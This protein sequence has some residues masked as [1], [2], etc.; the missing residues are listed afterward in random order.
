MKI[1]FFMKIAMA[2]I[3]ITFAISVF[4]QPANVYLIGGPVNK[5]NPNWLLNHKVELTKDSNNPA[6][7]DYKG[8][9]AYNWRGDESGNIKFSIG[10]DWGGAFHTNPVFLQ[11]IRQLLPDKHKHCCN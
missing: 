4:A 5:N 6:V 2:F 11:P 1:N 7:F 3:A 8:Y 10:N 9:L